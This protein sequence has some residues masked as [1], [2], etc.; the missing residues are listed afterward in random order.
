MASVRGLSATTKVCENQEAVEKLN[1]PISQAPS[2]SD[3]ADRA[4]PHL[5]SS[6]YRV[7]ILVAERRKGLAEFSYGRLADVA[8]WQTL[9][10]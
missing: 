9:R 8:G 5:S 1:E 3:R 2:L 6:T 7:T 10:T 4:V